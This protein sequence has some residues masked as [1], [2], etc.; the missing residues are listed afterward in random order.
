[1]NNQAVF[2]L[3]RAAESN[4]KKIAPNHIPWAGHLASDPDTK[5]RFDFTSTGLATLADMLGKGMM[6]RVEEGHDALLFTFN[7][8]WEVGETVTNT[9]VPGNEYTMKKIHGCL[10]AVGEGEVIRRR[11]AEF[12]V[13]LTWE[14]IPGHGRDLALASI[15]PG[16]PDAPANLEGLAEGDVLS[17]EQLAQRGIVRVC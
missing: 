10:Q 12:T 17:A 11:T 5:S 3:F 8:G 13:V 16:R 2:E 4:L 6:V 14:E 7:A 1:M 9:P 15:H